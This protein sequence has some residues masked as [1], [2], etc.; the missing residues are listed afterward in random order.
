[1][2][3]MFCTASVIGK[4]QAASLRIALEKA[5]HMLHDDGSARNPEQSREYGLAL[6]YTE[7]QRR[8]RSWRTGLKLL[9]WSFLIAAPFGYSMA[10]TTLSSDL[11][12]DWFREWVAAT[13]PLSNAWSHASHSVSRAAANLY[14]TEPSA[15]LIFTHFAT[16]DIILIILAAALALTAV[17]RLRPNIPD[18]EALAVLRQTYRGFPIT[19]GFN[20]QT[21]GGKF[22]GL[23]LA[24]VVV[25]FTPLALYFSYAEPLLRS[26][27]FFIDAHSH[28]VVYDAPWWS[29]HRDCIQYADNNLAQTVWKMGWM[30]SLAVLV[31]SFGIWFTAVMAIYPVWIWR[32]KPNRA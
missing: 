28:C 32:Q 23:L 7:R 12:A 31:I 9:V 1:M 29:K 8:R 24:L 6:A 20:P 3:R 25:I 16:F 19:R 17:A 4:G 5:S 15:L 27:Q 11:T 30:S 13:N 21:V 18:S 26:G 14:P 10:A 2:M 22:G